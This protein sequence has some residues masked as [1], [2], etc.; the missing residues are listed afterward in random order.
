MRILFVVPNIVSYHFFIGDVCAALR[1][2]GHDP[3]AVC[4]M[5]G[6]FG[7]GETADDR[8]TMHALDFP[9]GMQPL[10]HL[11]AARELDALVR[12]LQPDIIHTHFSAALFTTAVARRAHW[13]LTHG[14]YHG[15]SFPMMSG[16][17]RHILRF[18]ES[19]AASRFDDV[20]VLTPD[21]RAAL[22][23]AAPSARV[24]VYR[25]PGIGC[26]LEPFH[27]D[28]VPAAER[29]ALRAELGI[30]AEAIVFVFV[31]RL[32][33]F[34]GFGLTV[35]AFL[36]LAAEHPRYWLLNVGPADPLHP[37]GLTPEEQRAREECPRIVDVGMRK[38]VWRYLA[39][40]DVMT[41]PS[42]R[43]GM[44]VCIMEALAMGVPVITADSRG[45][46][47][48][49]RDEV[50]GLVLRDPGVEALGAAMRRLGEDTAF[51]QR[52]GAAAL[53]DRERFSRDGYVRE[54]VELYEQHLAAARAP[55]RNPIGAPLWKR[56][57]DF[58]AAGCALVALM[59]VMLFT[60][61]LIAV[62]L[63]RPVL[64]RQPRPGL[65]GRAFTMWKFRT[66][67]DARDA[68]GNLL[69][70]GERL[71]P[72][73]TWLR[74][75]SLDEL[76]ELW[77]VLRGDMS[78]VGPRPLLMVYLG[79]YS[80]EQDRRHDA[81]P[82]ITG[83]AQVNGRNAQ[84]WERKFALDTWYVDHVSPRLDL[85]ILWKTIARVL[86]RDGIAA[87]PEHV[88]SPH[89]WGSTPEEERQGA[90]EAARLAPEFA[91]RDARRPA[92]TT[93]R[94]LGA[95]LGVNF[96]FLALAAALG[97]WLRGEPTSLIGDNRP[98]SDF[99]ALQLLVVA[100]LA[101]A[102]YHAR[103]PDSEGPHL[104]QPRLVWL[105]IALGFCFLTVDQLFDLHERADR[106]IHTL[107]R[108]QETAWTDRLD[109]LIVISFGVCGLGVLF[110]C[111]RELTKF[112]G[113]L[114]FL[115]IGFVFFGLSAAC[116]IASNRHDLLPS[117]FANPTIGEGVY[118]WVAAADQI[119]TVIAE[120]FFAAGFYYVW[121]L[122]RRVRE[123]RVEASGAATPS[124]LPVA[125]S[126]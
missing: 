20:W 7:G 19:W 21:D 27:P 126:A 34:K 103:K 73:G 37:S 88:T 75:T 77:N 71:P 47:D 26:L 49:V 120:C 40:S 86:K 118:R 96:L 29:A 5:N 107:F 38:D 84:S 2:A 80:A 109:D 92:P 87:G 16:L 106:A 44:P 52:L 13:P 94:F 82:G 65:G 102:I 69:P 23:E 36:R 108:I 11:R 63:G 25:S 48:V 117:F 110:A 99:S 17:K 3:H 79:R 60:A 105:L 51:R 31:G 89:F 101:M 55:R 98:V 9:R 30:P 78:L 45:C 113:L 4:G 28:R 15:A 57:F 62:K 83:W 50:D 70:D 121:R 33:N 114:P 115:A 81:L 111:R 14:T 56:L 18:A 6:S 123:P 53:A 58:V 39:I 76:P 67:T 116:D 100:W 46:R 24:H 8:A 90:A 43:E 122:A 22:Q 41:F 97:W 93:P 59:P 1:A 104:Q 64:F 35:R 74:S 91:Q 68:A 124:L 119:F 72:F 61:A 125:E 42:Q 32:V 12:E 66:M 85:L 54:Q 112:F 95:M 10:Q